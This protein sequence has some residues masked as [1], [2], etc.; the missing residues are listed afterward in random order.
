M[1]YW[2][3]IQILLLNLDL[4]LQ[5]VLIKGILRQICIK[6]LSVYGF[7]ECEGYLLTYIYPPPPV[8]IWVDLCMSECIFGVVFV[9]GG[10]ESF[11]QDTGRLSFKSL[12]TCF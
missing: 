1:F 5:N 8:G 12:I 7:L 11:A 4:K 10:S 9:G 2:L 3:A 6:I